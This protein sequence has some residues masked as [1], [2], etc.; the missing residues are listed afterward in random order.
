MFW[1]D[2]IYSFGYP[3]P[4]NVIIQWWNY[5]SNKDLALRNALKAGYPVVCS[6]NYYNYLNFPVTPRKGYQENRTFDIRDAYMKNPSY[7]AIQE[8]NPLIWGMT[9]VL[10]TDDGVKIPLYSPTFTNTKF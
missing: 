10:W 6:S 3:L 9:C 5:R 4:D 8:N 2:V 1:G 7:K